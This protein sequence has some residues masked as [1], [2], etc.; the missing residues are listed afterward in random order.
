MLVAP[1]RRRNLPT[2]HERTCRPRLDWQ[3]VSYPN[4][5]TNKRLPSPC[6]PLNQNSPPDKR[7]WYTHPAMARAEHNMLQIIADCL[8]VS[9]PRRHETGVC[10][11]GPHKIIQAPS[12]GS[13]I[14]LSETREFISRKDFAFTCFG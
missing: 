10:T 8:S 12:I 4:E 6:Y 7:C 13:G 5:M 3:V 1:P 14:G 11:F 9:T 2:P